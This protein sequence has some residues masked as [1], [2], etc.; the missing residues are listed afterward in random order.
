[1]L[2][3]QVM[4][5]CSSA[6]GQ[7]T[8]ASTLADG[9][10]HRWACATCLGTVRKYG[11][12]VLATPVPAGQLQRACGVAVDGGPV[13]HLHG[14]EPVVRHKTQQQ[15]CGQLIQGPAA[16]SRLESGAGAV[17][18]LLEQVCAGV[19]GVRGL[20]LEP[21]GEQGGGGVHRAQRALPCAA[22][23]ARALGDGREGSAAG[24]PQKGA[25]VAGPALGTVRTAGH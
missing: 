1:V 18:C 9:T 13:S 2:S 11:S 24:Q 4:H 17:H 16:G 7:S 6:S 3:W 19:P 5:R 12:F 25:G 22:D 10:T 23:A 20:S 14:A 21:P 8:M 15:G